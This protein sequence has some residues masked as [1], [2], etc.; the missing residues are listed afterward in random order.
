MGKNRFFL[1]AGIFA[2]LVFGIVLFLSLTDN[3]L[4]SN[5]TISFTPPVETPIPITQPKKKASSP[6]QASAETSLP[7]ASN[8]I[9]D[10]SCTLADHLENFTLH[11]QDAMGNPIASGTVSAG[12]KEYT[13]AQGELIIASLT[14]AEILSVSAEGYS[15]VTT[16]IRPEMGTGLTIILD[17][18]NSFE[19]YVYGTDQQTPMPDASIRLWKMKSPDRPPV[20][21]YPVIFSGKENRSIPAYIQLKDSE[22]RLS[23]A[24]DFSLSSLE[25][26]FIDMSGRGKPNAGD[27]IL[28]LGN[29]SWSTNFSPGSYHKEFGGREWI[30]Y[31]YL[32]RADI[33]SN[34][35]RI[36]DTLSFAS[37]EEN[38]QHSLLMEKC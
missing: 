8:K 16:I 20:Q 30:E 2:V 35:L 22:Y 4:P 14:P 29:C 24:R 17:Y 26:N 34:K 32:P 11:I 33:K 5:V 10:P 37:N 23:Q 9:I 12:S 6:E 1:F 25:A 28:A 13:F 3:P 15:P 36:S 21:K 19:L 18:V 27:T 31:A 7:S 38:I